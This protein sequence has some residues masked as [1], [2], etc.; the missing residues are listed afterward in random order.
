MV[1]ENDL[2]GQVEE[3]LPRKQ[4]DKKGE[5][6]QGFNSQRKKLRKDPS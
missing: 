2:E 3:M 5:S 4:S 1:W 6:P